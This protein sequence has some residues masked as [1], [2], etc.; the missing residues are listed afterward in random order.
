VDGGQQ[1]QICRQLGVEGFPTFI[2]YK[3]GK[4]VWRTTGLVEA[5]TLKAQL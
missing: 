5:K 4:E 1:E 3:Q 2:V